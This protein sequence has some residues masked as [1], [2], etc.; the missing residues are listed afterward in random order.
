V[1]W[2]IED[3]SRDIWMLLP[4]AAV[5]FADT[6]RGMLYRADRQVLKSM[7]A[8]VW[9]EELPPTRVLFTLI[10]PLPDTE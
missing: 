9:A 2:L 3:S 10:V 6:Y 1:A 8:G 4:F 5:R 7:L